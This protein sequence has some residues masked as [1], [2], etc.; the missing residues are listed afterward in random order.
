MEH[1]QMKGMRRRCDG[2]KGFVA[3]GIYCGI[4]KVKKD[5]AIIRSSKPAVTAGFLH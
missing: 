3:G 2:A 4:R 1:D 5:I